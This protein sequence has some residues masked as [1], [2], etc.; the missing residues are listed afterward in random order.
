MSMKLTEKD[1]YVMKIFILQLG[2]HALELYVA[3]LLLI[4]IIFED[5]FFSF[6]T[7]I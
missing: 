6:L 2:V 5:F 7:T 3:M 4:K 1:N